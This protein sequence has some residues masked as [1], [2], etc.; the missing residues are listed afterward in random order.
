MGL[1]FPVI[2]LVAYEI[3]WKTGLVQYV[4]PDSF[5]SGSPTVIFLGALFIQMTVGTAIGLITS[6][7]EELGWRGI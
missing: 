7:G 1:P 6:T 2:S 5:S 3:A 4:I